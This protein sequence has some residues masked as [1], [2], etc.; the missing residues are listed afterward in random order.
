MR[1]SLRHITNG[2]E[3][4]FAVIDAD[5]QIVKELRHCRN[6]TEARKAYRDIVAAL[7]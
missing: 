5:D 3:S 1:Y 7:G 4:F 2:R 6:W